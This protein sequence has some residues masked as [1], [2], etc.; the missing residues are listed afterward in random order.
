[1]KRYAGIGAAIGA[2]IVLGSHDDFGSGACCS[3]ALRTR[4]TITSDTS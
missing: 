1:M 4:H 2:T 3:C